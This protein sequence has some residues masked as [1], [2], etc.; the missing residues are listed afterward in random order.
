[1]GTDLVVLAPEDAFEAGPM[2]Q[3]LFADWDR[4]FSRFR[5]DSELSVV[6]AAAG[7]AVEV[8]EG[9]LEVTRVAI[10]A[11]GATDGLFDPTLELLLIDLG[12]DRTFADLPADRPASAFD[13]WRSGGWRGIDLDATRRTVRLPAGVGLDFGGIAKG[14][15]VDAAIGRLAALGISPAAVS[16]GG[17]LAVIGSPAGSAAWSIELT[18]VEGQPIVDLSAG[19]LAT[20]SVTKRR[21]RAGG[22]DRHHLVDPRTGCPAA[23]GLRSV[24]VVARDCRQAEV[25]AKVALLLGPVKGAAFL[26]SRH[27]A[28]VLCAQDGHLDV[29]GAWGSTV[30]STPLAGVG[31]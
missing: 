8:S 3:A 12:Y 19:A 30:A 25:A 28:G 7:R 21:W 29:V 13:R 11:A 10:A 22:E 24:S 16:A 31:A 26:E 18:E 4:R 5:P 2:V 6:N 15:A 20:S 27:L 1:M 23:S 9:F 14:M 17:D